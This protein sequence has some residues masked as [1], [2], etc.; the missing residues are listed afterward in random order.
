MKI[1]IYSTSIRFV[2]I[3][4][5]TSSFCVAQTFLP[6]PTSAVSGGG[7]HQTQ[8]S[9]GQLPLD[10]EMN[11]GQTDGQVKFFARGPHYTVF[12]TSGQ[13]VLTLR[14]S[15]TLPDTAALS[16]HSQ[17]AIASVNSFVP[18]SGRASVSES[19]EMKLIGAASDPVIVGEEQQP[20]MANYFIGNDPN[21]WQTN[22]PI[23]KKVHYKNIYPGIDLAYYSSQLRIEHDYI[24]AAGSNPNQIQLKINGAD[25]VNVDANG[26]LIL[27]KHGDEIRLQAPVA[28]QESNGIRTGVE[29]KYSVQASGRVHFAIGK[30][31]KTKSLVIDPVL[32]YGTYLGGSGFD[33]GTGIAVDNDGNSYIAGCTDSTDFPLAS[34]NQTAPSSMNAFIAKVNSS[35]S[36]LVYADYIGGSS[37]DC[38][39]AMTLDGS[40]DAYLT[41]GTYSQDFPTVSPYQSANNSNA[42]AAFVT[43]VSPDG[44]SL[45]YSTYLS[46][47]AY[48]R[49]SS[50]GLD[51]SGDIYVA[52]WTQS[53]DFPVAN[54]YQ[55]AVSP[56]QGGNYGQYGFVTEFAAGG[57]SLVYSTYYAGSATASPG[58]QSCWPLPYSNITGMTVAPSGNVYVTGDTN[59]DDF[60]VTQ[61][62]YQTARETNDNAAVGF[63]GTF[64]SSG[65]LTN[66]TYYGAQPTSSGFLGL[67]PSAIAIDSNGSTYVV[68][69]TYNGGNPIPVTTPNLCNPAQTQCSIGFITKFDPTGLNVIYSTYLSPGIDVEPIAVTVDSN[70]DA[71]VYSQS[72]GGPS[73]PLTDPIET[74][75]GGEDVFIQ[76]IDPTGGVQLFGSFV[77]G[78]SDDLPGGM[79][80]DSAGNIYLTGF[81]DSTDFPTLTGVLQA[82]Y[83]GN[84]DAFITKIGT[85]SA[86]APAIA[87]SSVDFPGTAVGSS[88]QPSTVLLRN[89][90]SATLTI[91]KI[92]TSGDFSQSNTCGTAVA[93]AGSCSFSV[94]FTPTQAGSLSGSI[95]IS[96]DATG[97]PRVISLQGTGLSLAASVSPSQLAFSN[98]DVG[99]VS[100]AQSVTL[101]NTGTANLTI[102]NISLAGE[103]EQTNNCPSS[104]AAGASCQFQVQFAPTAAG[105]QNGT[106]SITDNATGSPQE[107]TL[108]GTGVCAGSKC[109]PF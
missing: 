104:L 4:L 82:T 56:N 44:S 102:S 24:V 57:Q 16:D 47:S 11:K 68:G 46:G 36:A 20:G 66:S 99:Q 43:E 91:S 2:Q 32:V 107:V 22:V 101:T 25:E 27:K 60:P 95:S 106:L 65:G 79:A 21:K 86:P 89:M 94:T 31:D 38:A 15:E 71:Y 90:G 93:A 75:S 3:L 105:A 67:W 69:T 6:A 88:S 78:S 77:G 7:A 100:A 50:L 84:D 83:D 54:A 108:T 103:Y 48:T 51:S 39:S 34:S 14:H 98:E 10:F 19:I 58:C 92:T 62:A 52:G 73:G 61:N 72:S 29:A 45:L 74:Y 28:Y 59:T 26:D 81:T 42:S 30:Y 97:F 76:E 63:I 109:N 41:G 49:A 13:M 53:T 1:A 5:L 40:D 9:Y 37:Y 70:G 85:E 55:S 18:G 96:N 12:L 35:G 64:S 87:P 33:Q 17:S 23:Y 80:V 8:T